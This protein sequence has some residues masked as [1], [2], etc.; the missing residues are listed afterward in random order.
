VAQYNLHANDRQQ[1][2]AEA[3]RRVCYGLGKVISDD[4]VFL[5]LVGEFVRLLL[6][7]MYARTRIR[8][9]SL[10]RRTLRAGLLLSSAR[11]GSHPSGGW[12][13]VLCCTPRC[14]RASASYTSSSKPSS[15][16]RLRACS[17][18]RQDRL[19]WTQEFDP[20]CQG[21]IG[22]ECIRALKSELH[23]NHFSGIHRR[24]S[25]TNFFRTRLA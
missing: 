5:S 9:G 24:G 22:G 16:S 1:L 4:T 20:Q 19:I 11:I 3:F 7:S 10:R 23:A 8:T 2:G 18:T 17:L 14:A 6:F 15:C 21:A 12:T 13:K 25:L